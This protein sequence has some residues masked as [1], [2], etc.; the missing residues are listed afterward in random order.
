MFYDP[1]DRSKLDYWAA[2]LLHGEAY[3]RWFDKSFNFIVFKNG[4]FGINTEHSW[5]DAAVTAHFVEYVVFKDHQEVG[6]TDNG[7]CKGQAEVVVHPTRLKWDLNEEVQVI[8][9]FICNI[10]NIHLVHIML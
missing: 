10:F 3:D 2:S 8:F 5:G 4:R 1:N 6:Y 9:L 7:D